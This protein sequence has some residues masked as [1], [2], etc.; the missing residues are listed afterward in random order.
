M[1]VVVCKLHTNEIERQEDLPT[2]IAHFYVRNDDMRRMLRW[3]MCTLTHD[4][5]IRWTPVRLSIVTPTRSPLRS[6]P[7]KTSRLR[8]EVPEVDDDDDVVKKRKIHE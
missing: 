6:S 4:P 3:V 1:P 7:I 8:M 5:E 2:N